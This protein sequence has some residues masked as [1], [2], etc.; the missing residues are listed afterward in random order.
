MYSSSESVTSLTPYTQTAITGSVL[1]GEAPADI[2]VVSEDVG[3]F[4]APIIAEGDQSADPPAPSQQLFID[5]E[6]E[7]DMSAHREAKARLWDNWRQAKEELTLR[8]AQLEGAAP[9]LR[10]AS[11]W[12]AL[13]TVGDT[14]AIKV[15]QSGSTCYDA[16]VGGT[17]VSEA[18][19]AVVRYIGTSAIYMEDTENPLSE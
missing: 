12:R 11:P 16:S 9:G 18:I 14:I 6:H 7:A 8:E 13:S 15:Y 19:S 1:G 4:E 10:V 3:Y 5:P 17:G 2:P